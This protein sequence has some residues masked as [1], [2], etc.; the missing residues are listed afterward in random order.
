MKNYKEIKMDY[1]EEKYEARFIGPFYTVELVD[2][3]AF[4]QEVMDANPDKDFLGYDA[5][6]LRDCIHDTNAQH[7]CQWFSEYIDDKLNANPDFFD[8]VNDSELFYVTPY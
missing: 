2:E 7:V 5:Q 4:I 8:D 1:L 3:K 6:F